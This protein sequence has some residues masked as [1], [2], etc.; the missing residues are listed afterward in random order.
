MFKTSI[1]FE[2][3]K[4]KTPYNYSKLLVAI[5]TLNSSSFFGYKNILEL[6]LVEII[7]IGNNHSL[8]NT[9]NRKK[10]QVVSSDYYSISF[11]FLYTK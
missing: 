6:Y 4:T 2:N 8:V 5:S 1:Y 7:K 3:F 11:I 10:H 9:N